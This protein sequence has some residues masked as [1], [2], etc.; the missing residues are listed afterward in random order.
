[1]S[2]TKKKYGIILLF[3][4]GLITAETS[5]RMPKDDDNGITTR[6][7]RIIP[8]NI[9]HEEL[10]S[11]MRDISTALG[12]KCGFCH[13]AVKGQLTAE[14]RQV[15]DFASDDIAHKRIARKMMMMTKEINEELDDISDGKFERVDCITCHRGFAHPSAGLDTASSD[16]RQ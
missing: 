11:I 1:M 15:Y 16:T 4:L 9:P 10:I 14:G 13:V 8:Q 7:L 12:V 5:A 2:G 6:N 3:M